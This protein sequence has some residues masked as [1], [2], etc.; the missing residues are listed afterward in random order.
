MPFTFRPGET[1][2][3]GFVTLVNFETELPA[4]MTYLK[5]KNIIIKHM[6][7]RRKTLDDL[8]VSL[9]GRKINE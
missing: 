5:S 3:K 4:F 8:F 9:T 6:E 7:C 2:E 1:P